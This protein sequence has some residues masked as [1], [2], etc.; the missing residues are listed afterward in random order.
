VSAGAFVAFRRLS[1]SVVPT[2]SGKHTVGALGAGD[3]QGES[4]SHRFPS[5]S[6]STGVEESVEPKTHSIHRR[7]TVLSDDGDKFAD[8][9]RNV[10]LSS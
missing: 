2:V 1:F 3:S 4:L 7:I 10:W 9:L 8:L 5:W 6:D